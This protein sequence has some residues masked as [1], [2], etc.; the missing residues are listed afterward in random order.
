MIVAFD[1]MII[2]SG[3]SRCVDPWFLCCVPRMHMDIECLSEIKV[4]Q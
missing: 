4:D 1:I 2:V 3:H